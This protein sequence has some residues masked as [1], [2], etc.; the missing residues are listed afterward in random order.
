MTEGQNPVPLAQRSLRPAARIRQHRLWG[1]FLK[2]LGNIGLVIGAGAGVDAWR[3]MHTHPVTFGLAPW[4][5]ELCVS[6]VTLM[7]GRWAVRQ[8]QRHQEPVLRSME[9]LPDDEEIVLFLRAFA[10]DKGLASIPSG[11]PRDAPWLSMPLTEEQQIGRATAP[12]GRL[13]AL[14]RPSDKLPQAGAARHYASDHAWQTE[15]L[16]AMDRA[17]L[18]LLVC[19]PGR[20]LRWEA[21]QVVA[22]NEPERLVLIGVRDAAQ[23]A[24]F[25][26]ANQDLFP[27][28]LPDKFSAPPS[29][30]HRA[31][32]FVCMVIWFDTDWTPHPVT[33]GA[34]DPDV[35]VRKLIKV[36]A[37][38][39][40][41]F[42]LAMRQVFLRAG[43]LIP[44]LPA[45]RIYRRP[46][47]VKAAA[48]IY[49]L[50]L[51]DLFFWGGGPADMGMVPA[52]CLM[53]MFFFRVWQGGHL[54]VL[55][56]YTFSM[57]GAFVCLLFPL[58]EFRLWHVHVGTAEWCSWLS[59]GAC[60]GVS[61]QLL[62]RESVGL[63]VASQALV[64]TRTIR[65]G[66]GMPD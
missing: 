52:A 47:A 14:G 53:L 9:T 48:A 20:S 57:E 40:T 7:G 44:G 16:T 25:K 3:A 66:R 64:A 31:P 58:L 54:A 36:D 24:S 63:W 18:I 41:A 28:G 10:D 1:R 60:L 26:V 4:P 8:G 2:V 27:K 15:V 21:E 34:E 59:L 37:W 39:E 33:L 49:L 55:F 5:V 62:R 12:F 13:V 32:T 38:I 23:Y 61:A 45:E 19:G 51:A 6:A 43:R 22:R 11:P 56:A 46:A 35:R 42:P 50:S 29:G 30:G 17:S 65:R